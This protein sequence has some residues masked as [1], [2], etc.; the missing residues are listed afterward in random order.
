MVAEK[1]LIVVVVFI[2]Y[3][4]SRCKETDQEKELVFLFVFEGL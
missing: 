3:V 2:F 4:V 1:L